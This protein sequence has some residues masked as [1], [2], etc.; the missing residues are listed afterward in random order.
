MFKYILVQKNNLFGLHIVGLDLSNHTK[1]KLKYHNMK[2]IKALK[3]KKRLASNINKLQD[4]INKK[5][6]Y[7]KENS[8]TKTEYPTKELCKTLEKTV[9]KLII[10]KIAINDANTGI[11]GKIYELG[12]CK[13]LMIFFRELNTKTGTVQ[14]Y[15]NII[16][17]WI[18]QITEKEAE[19]L[20]L[21]YQN[22]ADKLQDEIDAYNHMT[23]IN[24]EIS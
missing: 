8:T 21:N 14:N 15:T 20:F 4:L 12:E 2:L 23:T 6:S 17:T 10:L 9:N 18:T 11:Q 3:L 16:Q 13:S 19:E 5:N 1:L 7:L 22:I 24:F